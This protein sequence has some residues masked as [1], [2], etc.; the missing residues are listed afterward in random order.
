MQLTDKE[1]KTSITGLITTLRI[2][3]YFNANVLSKDI[4]PYQG[5]DQIKRRK[6]VDG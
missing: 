1:W 2:R 6:R 3:G 5:F 4:I